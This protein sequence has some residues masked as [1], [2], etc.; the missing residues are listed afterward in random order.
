MISKIK[1]N[2]PTIK[3]L[4]LSNQSALVKISKD[5]KIKIQAQLAENVQHNSHI[6]ELNLE[7]LDLDDAFAVS[8]AHSL[9]NN[10]VLEILNLNNNNISGIG[11]QAFANMLSVNSTLKEL[12]MKNQDSK[13]GNEG[14]E[15]M[16]AIMEINNTLTKVEIDFSDA[17]VK[18]W[19]EKRL[20]ANL[21]RQ[22][23]N[24]EEDQSFDHSQ[25]QFVLVSL[26]IYLFI[27]FIYYFFF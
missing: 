4:N 1:T 23:R 12:Y 11:A 18:E 21:N 22:S 3:I 13:L 20:S 5:E 7:N 17:S 19:M 10:R 26:F 8:L 9:M 14:E 2:D 24:E 27:Y 15:A 16:L 6:V 25:F